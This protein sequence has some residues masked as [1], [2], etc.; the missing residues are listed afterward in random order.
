MG[1]QKASR[2]E[3][4]VPRDAEFIFKEA[5][6]Y[7]CHLAAIYFFDDSNNKDSEPSRA[8]AV[9]WMA[10]RLGA[11]PLLTRRLQRVPFDLGYPYWVPTSVDVERHVF[12]A[13]A[14][15]PGWGE[16]NA[17]LSKM[18]KEPMDLVL[19]PWELHVMTGV[20][21]I[22]GLPEQVTLVA[23]KLHHSAADGLGTRDL[24][25]ALFDPQAPTAHVER[26]EPTI[27][28]WSA[29]LRALVGA[30]QAALRF[31]R[32]LK[33]A[34]AAAAELESAEEAGVLQPVQLSSGTRLNGPRGDATSVDFVRLGRAR[35]NEVRNAATGATVN[36]VVLA[37]VGRALATYLMEIGDPSSESLTAMV[38]RSMRGIGADNS[39]NL[40]DLMAIDMHSTIVDPLDRL[41]AISESGQVAKRRSGHPATLVYKN[42]IEAA[43]APLLSLAGTL[44]RLVPGEDEG[45][46]SSHTTVSN[47][48]L[49]IDG[50][51]YRGAPA[52]ALLGCQPPLDGDGVRHFLTVSAEDYF[53]LCVSSSTAI[54]PDPTR[55]L[56]I[57]EGVFDEICGAAK[58]S[59]A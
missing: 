34:R 52:A 13:H 9:K 24:T 30:P 17:Y 48:P 39:A 42:R 58:N 36:D 59:S 18:L 32:G 12:T 15:Q 35:I 50:C 22:V 56:T 29:G 27:S 25:L 45:P 47:I 31:L 23:L 20:S 4:L 51:E 8:A 21:G 44:R 38:P 57:L 33:V 1:T 19:P 53:I 5:K 2:L 7:Q 14:A 41:E 26:V 49:S 3:Q 55:Y 46:R 40:V 6:D 37:V 43:P 28:E 11:A 16:V 54:M 10:E